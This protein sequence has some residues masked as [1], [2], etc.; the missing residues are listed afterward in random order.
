MRRIVS[1]GFASSILVA[2]LGSPAG[3]D[4]SND[5]FADAIVVDAVPFSYETD[6]NGAGTE[7]GEPSLCG[8]PEHGSTVWFRYA[9]S[10]DALVLATTRESLFDTM[11]AVYRGDALASLDPVACDDDAGPGLTSLVEFSAQAGLTYSIQ[12]GGYFAD[13]GLLRFQLN[14]PGRVTGTVRDRD[15]AP[16]EGIC[17]NAY[18]QGDYYLEHVAS[19][20]TSSAGTYELALAGGPVLIRFDD[21]GAGL[22]IGEWYDDAAS[23]DLADPVAVIGGGTTAG[24]DAVLARAGSISGI[25]TDAAGKPIR[26][27]CVDVHDATGDVAYGYTDRSGLYDVSGLAA[28]TYNVRFEDCEHYPAVWSGEWYA[29]AQ[30]IVAATPVAVA[31]GT[32]TGRIDA[33]LSL[34]PRPDIAITGVRVE[35]VPLQAGDQPLPAGTGWTRNVHVGFSNVG[36]DV[37]GEVRVTAQACPRTAG[38]C[39]TLRTFYVGDVAPGEALERTA[40]WNGFGSI[41]DWR[42]TVVADTEDDRDWD[43]NAIDEDAYVLVGGTGF[44]V[45]ACERIVFGFN[46]CVL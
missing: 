4:P 41:G 9:P 31:E 6:T 25:V 16:L 19:D 14:N 38:S 23:F 8:E 24:I 42:V 26:D 35:N 46:P 34:R 32:D 30:N 13:A 44:G 40:R 1:I 33:V 22:F 3:A 39:R 11:I 29:D 20:M 5:A 43:N 45:N 36:D 10:A 7:A 18:L 21:C 17:V 28:G 15:G 27:I 37:S 12:V 2:T